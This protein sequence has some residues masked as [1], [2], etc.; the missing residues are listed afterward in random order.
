MNLKT[1][2][3]NK[4][5]RNP[6]K[7]REKPSIQSNNKIKNSSQNLKPSYSK[8]KNTPVKKQTIESFDY[9]SEEKL[10][11]L[12]KN[13]IIKNE[14][15]NKLISKKIIKNES[16][17]NFDSNNT[18]NS[19]YEPKKNYYQYQPINLVKIVKIQR[20]YRNVVKVRYNI[21]NRKDIKIQ[22]MR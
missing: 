17:K 10:E 8:I 14:E 1:F 22:I 5:L 6:S 13:K 12:K 15:D 7:P 4:Q 3:T 2:D 18:K 16:F 19:Y 11:D 20:W 21:L 9:F